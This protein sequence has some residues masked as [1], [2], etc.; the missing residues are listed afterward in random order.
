MRRMFFV[1]GLLLA[2]AQVTHPQ[3]QSTVP[4]TLLWDHPGTDTTNFILERKLGTS[5]TYAEAASIV[6]TSRSYT[7]TVPVGQIYCWQVRAKNAFFQAAD[8][9]ANPP[10]ALKAKIDALFNGMFGGAA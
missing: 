3:A 10:A 5:G 2:F 1:C 7:D 8:Q 4:V 9:L 6:A